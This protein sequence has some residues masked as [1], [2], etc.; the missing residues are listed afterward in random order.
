MQNE[1]ADIVIV[2]VRTVAS[3]LLSTPAPAPVPAPEILAGTVVQ[4][5]GNELVVVLGCDT[6]KK[7]FC[8]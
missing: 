5:V 2:I 1:R 8:L 3:P 6:G 7:V 4:V